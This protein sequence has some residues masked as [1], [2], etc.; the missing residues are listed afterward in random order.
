MTG[1]VD[2]AINRARLTISLLIAVIVVGTVAYLSI[3]KEADPDIP[4]PYFLIQ[5]FLQ[6]ISP[7]DAERLIVKPHE[8]ELKTIEGL[9]EL[10]GIGAQGYAIVTLEFDVNFNKE[11][12]LRR[13]REKV[14]NAKAKLPRESVAS[15]IAARPHPIPPAAPLPGRLAIWV[16]CNRFASDSSIRPSAIACSNAI[17]DQ[18]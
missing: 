17:G 11:Q 8:I 4:I 16:Q 5:V 7:E 15:N 3:P 9:K 14:D 13:I 1:L 10:R 2:W 6:G 18:K 12:A